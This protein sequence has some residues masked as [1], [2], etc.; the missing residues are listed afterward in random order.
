MLNDDTTLGKKS[1]K[2]AKTKLTPEEVVD[3]AFW[4]LNRGY[5][6]HELAAMKH[7]N[8]G[9]VAEACRAIQ[10]AAEN[11]K[12]VYRIATGKIKITGSSD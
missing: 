3:V 7:I 8:A 4:H 10:W 6:Q 12:I 11:H 9:R 5:S 1:G 2:P